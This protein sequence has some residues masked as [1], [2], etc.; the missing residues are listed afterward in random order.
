MYVGPVYS[1]YEFTEPSSARMTDSEWETRINGNRLP[2]RPS[3]TSSFVAAPL[4]RHLAQPPLKQ[5]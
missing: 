1:Y 3:L 4:K 2:D 5:R